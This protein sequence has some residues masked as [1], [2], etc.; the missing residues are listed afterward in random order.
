VYDQLI[1]S[2]KKTGAKVMLIGVPKTTGFVSLRTGDELYQDRA[3]F[4]NFG[5]II[6]P[7]CQGNANSIFVPIK[8][9]TAVGTAQATGQPQTLSCSD[10]PGAQ[11][12]ILTPA[13]VQTLN[14][15]ID[16]MNSHIQSVAQ[17]NG[18]AYVDMATVWAQWVQRRPAFSVVKMFSCVNPYGQ[19]TSLDGVHPTVAGY[20]EMANAAADALNATYGFTIPTNPQAVLTAAQLCP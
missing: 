3:A 16:G 15:L 17:S 7:D 20:Q 18:W 8:V 14:T 13:D 12:N 2:V 10:Q 4:Q 1:D 5:V 9:T 6:S 11:D 19:Y